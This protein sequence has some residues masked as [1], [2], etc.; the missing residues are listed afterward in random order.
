MR[1]LP[2][3]FPCLEHLSFSC[4]EDPNTQLHKHFNQILPF[5]SLRSF[6]LGIYQSV[7]TFEQEQLQRCLDSYPL[8]FHAEYMAFVRKLFEQKKLE[9]KRKNIV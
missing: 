5:P 4:V 9:V 2:E 6:C 7:K 8:I 1:F 3:M